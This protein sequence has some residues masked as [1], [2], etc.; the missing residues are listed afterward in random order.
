MGI[1]L[2]GIA[3]GEASAQSKAETK[4]YNTVL[5]KK[6]LKNANKFLTKFPN[7]S[8]TPQVLRLRD[9][10]VFFSLDPND[11]TK[12]ISFTKQNPKSFFVQA[13]NKKIEELNTSSIT[14]TQAMEIATG[15]GFKREDI[16]GIKAVKDHNIDHI[17]M[18]IKD[19]DPSMLN[20]L[21]L[22]KPYSAWDQ[23]SGNGG[24]KYT[25][26][27]S[28][29]IVAVKDIKSVIING[30]Q[31]LYF[32]Y[33]NSS[34]AIDSRSGIPNNDCELVLNLY[35][36][37][38]N[39][40]YNVLFSGKTD[41]G[42]LYGSSMDIAQGGAMATPEQ[43]Y[44]IK[45][46]ASRE[47]LKPYDANRF[48]IQE[49]IQWWYANNPEGSKNISFGMIPQN[50]PLIEMANAGKEKERIGNYTVTMLNNVCNNTIIVVKD[51]QRGEYSL[52]M[53]QQTPKDKNSLELNTF[54][55]EKG[56]IMALYYY[57]GKTPFK[58]RLNL[59][60]KKLY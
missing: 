28:L 26:D 47:D 34:N 22:S 33:T 21:T 30:M 53:C 44:L 54:Y 9:S 51:N 35:S 4:L 48:Q 36:I 39:A 16:L 50:S 57:K 17:I 29:D 14:D 1:L 43:T 24:P 18:I 8:Y 12:Y 32:T 38:H 60:S 23:V 6:D 11:V 3:S 5:A 7:S 37:S 13:A 59:A 46:M 20:I 10:I 52:A 40:I 25:N 49:L 56:N 2:L 19:E 45:A 15:A 27:A 42:I 55:G 41:N 31:Y 58:K